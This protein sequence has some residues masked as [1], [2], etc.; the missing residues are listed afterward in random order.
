MF[1]P[2]LT[3]IDVVTAYLTFSEYV[4]VRWLT[5]PSVA[6]LNRSVVRQRRVL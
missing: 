1:S 3:V 2:F 5:M 6:R 4:T